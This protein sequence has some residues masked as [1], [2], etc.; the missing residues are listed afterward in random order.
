MGAPPGDSMTGTGVPSVTLKPCSRPSEF[1]IWPSWKICPWIG[2]RASR[3]SPVRRGRASRCWWMRSPCWWGPGAMGN[4]CAEGPSGPWWRPWWRAA[5]MR[6]GTSSPA[7]ACP[8]T[9]RWCCAGKWVRAAAAPGSTGPAAPCRI[10]ARRA[11]SGCASPVSTII[12]PCWGKSATWPSLTRCWVWS[13]PWK[14]RPR[15]CARRRPPSRP[16]VAARPSGNS[17][18]SSSPRPWQ[19]WTSWPRSRVNGSSCG[20]S[21]SPCAMPST[22]SRPS[23]RPPRPWATAC[24]RSNWPTRPW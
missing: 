20:P 15:P 13:R 23:G 11:G 1:R 12:S 7:G 2:D 6:G 5:S 8:R 3:Y 24:P 18:W 9:S 19:I 14:P 17:A 10:C 4:W 22:W 21:G 16:A